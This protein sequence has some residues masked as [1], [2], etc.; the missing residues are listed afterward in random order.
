MHALI[1]LTALR[2]DLIEGLAAAPHAKKFPAIYGTF[3][4]RRWRQNIIRPKIHQ[5]WTPTICP[6]HLTDIMCLVLQMNYSGPQISKLALNLLIS[7]ME[8]SYISSLAS[9][10]SLEYA[11]RIGIGKQLGVWVTSQF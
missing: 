4:D 10:A 1:Q 7:T 8:I 9:S 2:R 11:V 3:L 6:E 5:T